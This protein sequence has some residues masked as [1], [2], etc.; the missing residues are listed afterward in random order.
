M[1][2]SKQFIK[3][4]N[5]NNV[6]FSVIIPA[7]NEEKYIGGCLESIVQAAQLYKD[8]VEVIVVLIVVQIE[9]RK[10]QSHTIV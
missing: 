2:E 7:H 8:Q 10:L 3:D 4:I 1:S 6:K 9:Q 5:E